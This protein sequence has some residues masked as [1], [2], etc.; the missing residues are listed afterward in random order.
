MAYVFA[1]LGTAADGCPPGTHSEGSDLCCPDGSILGPDG[2]CVASVIA[3]GNP[4]PD[5]FHQEGTECVA[6]F[7]VPTGG[8]SPGQVQAPDGRCV[9]VSGG[10]SGGG[11]SSGGG[12]KEEP[13]PPVLQKSSLGDSA[14][15][16]LIALGLGGLAI[17]FTMAPS[18]G[19][20]RANRKRH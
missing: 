2:T 3:P 7:K 11:G 10:G 4:C 16:W 13:P 1:G 9:N 15:P 20:Y 8:C 14:A 17:A 18:A 5:G 6:D 12:G 19:G